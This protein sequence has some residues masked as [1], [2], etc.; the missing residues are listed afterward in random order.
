ML[1]LPLITLRSCHFPYLRTRFLRG[2][3]KVSLETEFSKDPFQ[4]AR[5]LTAV[6]ATI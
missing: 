3:E 1:A 2:L 6:I 4:V 5:E